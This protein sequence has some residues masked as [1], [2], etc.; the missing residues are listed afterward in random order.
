MASPQEAFSWS[1][2][3]KNNTKLFRK[4]ISYLYQNLSFQ[5]DKE[6]GNQIF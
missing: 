1:F 5:L 2:L 6:S 4:I 3:N